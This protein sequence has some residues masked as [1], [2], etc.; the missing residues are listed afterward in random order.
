MESIKYTGQIPCH[1]GMP[2]HGICLDCNGAALCMTCLLTDHLSH[3]KNILTIPAL[4]NKAHQSYLQQ[5][6][7]KQ[8]FRTDFNDVWN[9]KDESLTNLNAHIEQE[10]LKVTEV[11][12]ECQK[13]VLEKLQAIMGNILK[14]LDTQVGIL[15]SNWEF[16]EEKCNS[17]NGGENAKNEVKSVSDIFEDL[18]AI[19]D[20]TQLQKELNQLRMDASKRDADE[21]LNTLKSQLVALGLKIKDTLSLK[22]SV[23]K[24]LESVEATTNDIIQNIL[25]KLS[26][27][28]QFCFPSHSLIKSLDIH[29][30][31]ASNIVKSIADEEKLMS[32][33]PTKPSK[34]SLLYRGSRD[35][36]TG[37]AFHSKADNK[38]NTI[39]LVEATTG[40]IFG[41]FNDLTWNETNNYK[42]SCNCFIFSITDSEKYLIKTQSLAMGCCCSPREYIAFGG[43]HDFCLA[44]GCNANLASYSNF[45][46]SYDSRNMKKDSLTGSERNF[47]VREVEV[48]SLEILM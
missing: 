18:S 15:K 48:Y 20:K 13:L 29:P 7:A 23:S 31:M 39:V 10:K 43:G 40:K 42:S 4:V 21:N 34:L 9:R 1:E 37:A 26:T 2:I 44:D 6:T 14:D 3:G 24:A 22:P 38:Q 8:A 11:F 30:R 5:Q 16:Y 36:F 27:E 25:T 41:G 45:G 32:W 17:F 28:Q 47:T 46:H 33:L 12:A 35:G 19:C